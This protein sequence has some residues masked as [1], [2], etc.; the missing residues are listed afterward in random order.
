MI[1]LEGEPD[2]CEVCGKEL[3]LYDNISCCSKCNTLI[4]EMEII[5]NKRLGLR[6][7]ICNDGSINL[8]MNVFTFISDS[9]KYIKNKIR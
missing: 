1:M 5:C 3:G 2:N 7:K 4:H 6:Y 9:F 8:Y